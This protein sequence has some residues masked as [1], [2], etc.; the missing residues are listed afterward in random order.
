MRDSKGFGVNLV[1]CELSW[2]RCLCLRVSSPAPCTCCILALFMF[3]LSFFWY[4][5][6]TNFSNANLVMKS[7]LVPQFL[8]VVVTSNI[9]ELVGRSWTRVCFCTFI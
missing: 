7:Q 2:T 6:R 1:I 8:V 5:L 9:I 4:L 3:A